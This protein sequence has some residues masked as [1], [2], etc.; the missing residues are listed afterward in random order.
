MCYECGD[1]FHNIEGLPAFEEF[2]LEEKRNY[3]Y[4]FT[5]TGITQVHDSELVDHEHVGGGHDHS[6]QHSHGMAAHSHDD[7]GDL[8]SNGGGHPASDGGVHTPQQ[9]APAPRYPTIDV[10]GYDDLMEYARA[11]V[12]KQKMSWDAGEHSDLELGARPGAGYDMDDGEFERVMM[13]VEDNYDHR[14]P[15]AIADAMRE[16]GAEVDIVS[17]EK[18]PDEIDPWEHELPGVHYGKKWGHPLLNMKGV[19]WWEDHAEED[20]H[21]DMLV[22]GVGGPNRKFETDTE[23]QRIPWRLEED[24]V[25]P[26]NTFPTEI[27]DI[28]NQKTAEVVQEAEE[29]H[30]KDPEGTDLQFTNYDE[31]GIYFKRDAPGHI[32]GHPSFLTPQ[33]DTTGVIAGTVNH[34][35]AFPRIEVELND[36]KVVDVRGGGEFGQIWR[37]MLDETEGIQYPGL[38]GPGL[39]WL[40]EMAIGTH[41]KVSR[42]PTEDISRV[43]YP[44]IERRR[45]G[46]IHCGFGIQYQIEPYAAKLEDI[47][48]GHVHVHLNFATY[49]AT[50]PDGKTV[51][52]IDDGHLTTLDHPDVREVA[53]EHGDPDE[54]LSE[55]WIPAV[56]GINE[57][58]DYHEDYAKDPAEWIER[59]MEEQARK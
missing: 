38:P 33:A 29:V 46:I 58:G 20:P 9:S 31:D 35:G 6:P 56:P 48:W 5:P 59:E 2:G 18:V 11:L 26:A 53:A 16:K 21:Y 57:D 36:A 23:Y 25:S 50:M 19:R 22:Y 52:L 12:D 34:A 45:S 32:F 39:F 54:L 1:V 24:L 28:I 44:E 30:L 27:W 15:E 7:A 49:E 17:I 8:R 47:P 43:Q 14:V 41:P 37:E 10:D 55:D 42:P 3:G 4:E 51:T 40:W 13:V